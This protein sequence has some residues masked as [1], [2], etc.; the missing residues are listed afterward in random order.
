MAISDVGIANLALQKLGAGRITSLTQDLREARSINACYEAIRDRELRAHPWSFAK[1]RAALAPA[2]DAPAFDFN[3]AFPL[4][5]DFLR[6]LRPNTTDLDWS[7]ERQG[8]VRCILTNDGSSI[9]LRY[10]CKITDPTEFDPMFVDALACKLAWH[11]CEEITQSNQKKADILAEY[12]M[13]ISE[14]RLANAIEAG[15]DDGPIDT[16]DLARIRGGSAIDRSRMPY[17]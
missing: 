12:K 14:A 13:V 16:W 7:I 17:A 6:L 9:N 3:Y 11:C 8:G 4:P 2:A 10:I 1:A 15:P 5:V